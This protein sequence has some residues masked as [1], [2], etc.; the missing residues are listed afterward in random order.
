MHFVAESVPGEIT[1]MFI[2]YLMFCTVLMYLFVKTDREW[3]RMEVSLDD[4]GRRDPEAMNASALLFSSAEI[5]PEPMFADVEVRQSLRHC[6][7][8]HDL[9]CTCFLHG[10]RKD[11][12]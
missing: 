11:D 6:A 12:V 10:Q 7:E 3:G 8:H 4:A 1:L 2:S 9:N 5:G